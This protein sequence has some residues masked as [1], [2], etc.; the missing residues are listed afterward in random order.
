MQTAARHY[1]GS[2]VGRVRDGNGRT[3]LHFAAQVAQLAMCSY[4]LDERQ[5]DVNVQDDR[6]EQG[7]TMS[8]LLLRKHAYFHDECL[9]QMLQMFA[10]CVQG[11]RPCASGGSWAAGHGYAAAVAWHDTKLTSFGDILTSWI[12]AHVCA[13]G[14]RRCRWR[15]ARGCWTL[16]LCCCRTVRTPTCAATA[17]PRPSTG[18]PPQVRL[19]CWRL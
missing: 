8:H 6:G 4:L 2:D 14:R 5:M 17:A 1:G 7:C 3:V 9:Q 10:W 15:R 12:H 13:Q 11:R 19:Q 18:R 16:L